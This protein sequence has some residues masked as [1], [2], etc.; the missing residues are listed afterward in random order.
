MA[1]FINLGEEVGVVGL[2]S[3]DSG[4]IALHG[5]VLEVGSEACHEFGVIFGAVPVHGDDRVIQGEYHVLWFVVQNQGVLPTQV[6]DGPQVFNA[7][8]VLRYC[9]VIPMKHE[10]YVRLEWVENIY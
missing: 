1:R 7:P 2:V 4:G 10:L 3:V 9:A 6:L 5:Q 8:L